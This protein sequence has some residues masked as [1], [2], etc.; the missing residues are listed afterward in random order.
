MIDIK[1]FAF[2]VTDSCPNSC[3]HCCFSSDLSKNN[4]LSLKNIE[5]TIEKLKSTGIKLIAFTGGEPFMLGKD[6]VK[7]VAIAKKR[8]FITRI[9]TSAFFA[10]NIEITREILY[11][12]KKAGLDELSISWDD[13]HEEFVPFNCISNAYTIAKELGISVGINIVQS[14][15]SRWT[16]ERVK[17]ELGIYSSCED[18]ISESPLN[19]TGRAIEELK[20]EG[21]R[22]ERFIGPCPYVLTGPALSA[23][24]KLLACCGVLSNVDQLTLE[25]NFNPDNINLLFNKLKS[26]VLLNWLH[27]RGPYNII[28]W[29]SEKYSIDVIE[30]TKIGGNCEACRIL[31]ETRE[32]L[33][34]LPNALEEKSKNISSELQLLNILGIQ[35][36]EYILNLWQ[37]DSN[38]T[39]YSSG[40]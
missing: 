23:E 1:S 25:S 34:K 27:L 22:T 28:E 31:F 16:A 33:E 8:D 14:A 5:H 37:D 39:T 11:E 10:K 6:L 40:S 18:V 19:L 2:Q 21:L 20:D 15:N 3:K 32:L 7:A 35:D 30:K 24:N 17:K 26:S 12:L 13:Y 9:V 38:V 29:I 4:R 36:P